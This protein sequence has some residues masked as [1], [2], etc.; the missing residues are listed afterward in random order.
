[1]AS[2]A[3]HLAGKVA[4]VT[5]SSQGIG[6]GIIRQLASHGATVIMHGKVPDSELQD[7]TS[8]LAKETGA[9]RVGFRNT[10][11]TKPAAIKTMISSIQQE[12]GSLDILV[13]NAGIQH[14][15]PVV[16]FP[17]DKVRHR[18][19]CVNHLFGTVGRAHRGLLVIGVPRHQ[20]GVA[21]DD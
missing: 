11:L 3:R 20:G 14:V 7:K 21:S 9:E 8:Q 1:M 4:L 10:D 15:A 5:G 2:P 19:C 12:H 6:L 17:E 13:N 18:C 16:D